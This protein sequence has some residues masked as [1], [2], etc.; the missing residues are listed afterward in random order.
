MTRDQ[1]IAGCLYR[2]IKNG[3]TYRVE[4]TVIHSESGEEL[5][6]YHE[7]NY[8]SFPDWVRPLDLFLEK[9]EPV[10]SNRRSCDCGR[11]TVPG[12]HWC[13]NP[14]WDYG[15]RGCKRLPEVTP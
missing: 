9:F 15:A 13:D 2:N 8:P 4:G 7:G 10:F 12:S 5:V 6:A 11:P 1:L 14:M 3:R